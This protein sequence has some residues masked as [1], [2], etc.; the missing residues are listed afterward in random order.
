M[1]RFQMTAGSVFLLLLT[2]GCVVAPR[3][4]QPMPGPYPGAYPSAYPPGYPPGYSSAYPDAYVPPPEYVVD[5]PVYYD[6]YPGVAFY[7]IFIDAP[8]SCFCV[9]PMRYYGGAWLS[10]T[11]SVIYRGFFPFRRVEP[12]HRSYWQQHGGIVNGMRPSRGA[13]ES[14]GA[15]IVPLPPAGSIHHRAMEERRMPEQRTPERAM[16]RT[17]PISPTAPSG[18]QSGPQQQQQPRELPRRDPESRRSVPPSGPEQQH[19][20]SRPC[21][22][23]D[24]KEH[25]C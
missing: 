22:D 4:M 2:A 7:P 19:Q 14:Q 23:V 25:R 20:R 21:G 5:G 8:G 18:P 9:M 13:F 12:V 3:P 16:P 10:V 6:T 1:T 24:K 15:R 11:G 17:A